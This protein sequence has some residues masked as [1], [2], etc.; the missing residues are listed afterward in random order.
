M[1]NV[2]S[3]SKFKPRAL[4]YFREVEQTGRELIIS[5]RGKPVLR[6]VPFTEDRDECLR[7]LRNSVIKFEDPTSPVGLDDWESLK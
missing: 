3:K 2:I 7:A 5:D 6:I 1:E 4:Q